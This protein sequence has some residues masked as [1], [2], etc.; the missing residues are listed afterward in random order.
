MADGRPWRDNLVKAVQLI[1]LATLVVLCI[2]AFKSPIAI[3]GMIGLV[4][5]GVWLIGMQYFDL[6]MQF[7][8]VLTAF[9]TLLLFEIAAILSLWAIELGLFATALVARLAFLVAS[10]LGFRAARAKGQTDGYE[11]LETIQEFISQYER[12]EEITPDDQ[13]HL[14]K[15][16]KSDTDSEDDE[17]PCEWVQLKDVLMTR[18]QP[19]DVVR[20]VSSFGPGK[21]ADAKVI[22]NRHGRQP[23][24][25]YPSSGR[26]RQAHK[27]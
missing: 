10:A 3:G 4:F 22:K 2:I 5:V 1:V 25:R 17:P 7:Q 13:E 21:H 11:L 6:F 19:G 18:P 20:V 24:S 26:K 16:C 23:L 9:F 27:I 12:K 8:F 15:K 14:V